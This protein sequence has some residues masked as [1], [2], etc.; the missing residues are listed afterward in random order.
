MPDKD[1]I[2]L[3]VERQAAARRLLATPLVT[4]DTHPEEFPLIHA[5]ADWL[6]RR[7]RALLGYELAVTADHARLTK[8]G[9]LEPVV[10]PLRRDSGARFTPRAYAYLALALAALAE[11]A[12]PVSLREMIDGVRLAARDAG[13]DLDPTDRRAERRPFV[14]AV[15]RL[16]EWGAVR[17]HGT[18]AD[19]TLAEYA[20]SGVG[21]ARFHVNHEI[22]RRLLARPP[23]SEA[24]A[25]EFLSAA[26][27]GAGSA[28]GAELALAVLRRL[29]ET[30]VVYREHLPEAQAVWLRHHQWRAVAELGQFLGCDAEVRA[31]GVAL[32]TRGTAAFPPPDATGQ[33]ALT[34]LTRLVAALRPQRTPATGV[35]IPP[36][37]LDTELRAITQEPVPG[38]PTD[39]ARMEGPAPTAEDVLRLLTDHGMLARST[40]SDAEAEWTLLAAASRYGAEPAEETP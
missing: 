39:R 17:E 40:G 21:D 26:R 29:A 37:V 38:D 25:E 22:I 14:A 31:E 34:L 3:I 9:L 6:T 33:A 24:G 2:A 4:R 8:T 32:V 5:H 15:N 11:L 13:L 10:W 16:R 18:A 28:D 7:F 1:D 19:G 12:N 30:A 23:R 35:A 20:K 36:D 27:E